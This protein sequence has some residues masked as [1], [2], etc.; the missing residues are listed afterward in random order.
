MGAIGQGRFKGAI[1]RLTGLG[2]GGKCADG[3]PRRRSSCTLPSAASKPSV[4]ANPDIFVGRIAERARIEAALKDLEAGRGRILMLVGEPGIGKSRLAEHL[5]DQARARGAEVLVGRCQDGGGAPPYW[6]WRQM[7]RSHLRQVGRDQALA[8]FGS[9]AVEIARVVD[10]VRPLI[11]ATPVTESL[12]PDEARFRFFDAFATFL[13]NASGG[14]PMVLWLDD[15]HWADQPSLLLLQALARELAE[16]PVLIVGTYREIEVAT[17][18]SRADVLGSLNR[19]RLYERLLLRG[20]SDDESRDLLAASLGD[21]MTAELATRLFQRTEG[22]PFFLKEMAR[23]LREQPVAAD[24]SLHVPEGVRAVLQQRLGKLGMPAM[25]VLDAASAAGRDFELALVATATETDLRSVLVHVGEAASLGLVQTLA[26][27]ATQARFTH[28]LVRER[29]YERMSVE[30]RAAVHRRV[31]EAIESLWPLE[32][33][34]HSG[35]LAHHFSIAAPTGTASKAVRYGSRAGALAMERTGYED[36]IRFYQQAIDAT[37]GDSSIDDGQLCHLY[38]GLGAA[39]S[40]VSK[41]KELRDTF[42]KAAELAGRIGNPELFAQAAVGFSR[43]PLVSGEVDHAAVELLEKALERL[44]KADSRLRAFVLSMLAYALH[45]DGK[46]SKRR[47]KLCREATAMARRVGDARCLSRVL[48]DQ[49]QALFAPENLADRFA[50]ANELLQLAEQ[51]QDRPMV[52]RARYCRV[53]DLFEYARVR[54]AELEIGS[55]ERLAEVLREPWQHWYGTWFRAAHAMMSGRFAEGEQLANDAYRIG[56]RVAPDLALQVFS[57]QFS[58]LRS[59]QGRFVEI[60]PSVRSAVEEYPAR[61]AWRCALAYQC[62]ESNE[63]EEARLH[64]EVL[65]ADDFASIPRDASWKVSISQLADVAEHLADRKRAAILYDI[66]LPYAEQLMVV[67][68]ALACSGIG[69]RYLGILATTVGR[70]EDAERHLQHALAMHEQCGMRP[71]V[72]FT[73]L[74]MARLIC[75]RDSAAAIDAVPWV[76]AALEIATELGMGGVLAKIEVLRT[77]Y[78]VLGEVRVTQESAGE[79]SPSDAG[80]PVSTAAESVFLREGDVWQIVF[81]GLACRLKDSRGLQYLGLLLRHPGR[82]FHVTEL[83][84]LAGGA[85]ATPKG[86]PDTGL[87]LQVQRDALPGL[88]ERARRAYRARLAELQ[89]EL[90]EA[91]GFNDAGAA[92]RAQR[93]IE[94]LTNEI[95]GTLRGTTAGERARV[96][97][98]KRLKD[99][100]DRIRR[101]HPVLADHLTATVKTGFLCSYTPDPRVPI[102][103][104]M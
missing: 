64:F 76:T 78:P 9:G 63:S 28:A 74:D 73:K 49:H 23:H 21:T 11:P 104:Q 16:V 18:R 66:L 98:A 8:E 67:D 25:E 26:P 87:D 10:E 61:T 39:H 102:D 22:N 27:G 15:L 50:A 100:L 24:E 7:V 65:A 40:A 103:W 38:L 3:A 75:T 86:V 85:V 42:E 70:W 95:A 58:M 20:L 96:S 13:F 43:V 79:E 55:L 92:E 68:S 44:P 46:E 82:Q 4:I 17:D 1:D 32:L 94:M 56:E 57:V 91:E 69:S 19:E 62:A 83:L 84:N 51:A 101:A 88:D 93:E 31:G 45:H 71:W 81:E 2:G 53:I 72:A 59:L 80:P 48:F 12:E 34:E 54:E 97:V 77:E 60:L 52:L 41:V 29:I 6:P 37:V 36:A 47:L 35:E 14:R 5:A 90:E 89:Q 30:R 33:D 99:A